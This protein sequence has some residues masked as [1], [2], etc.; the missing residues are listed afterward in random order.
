MGGAFDYMAEQGFDV[1]VVQEDLPET[2]VEQFKNFVRKFAGAVLNA[3]GTM[4]LYMTWA[5][6]CALV[7]VASVGGK[8]VCVCVCV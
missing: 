7:W 3:G 5:C 4:Y 8:C 6:E 1:V 2:T